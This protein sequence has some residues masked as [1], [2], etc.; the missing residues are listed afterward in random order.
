MWKIEYVLR[1]RDTGE[2]YMDWSS[3]QE[4]AD[5]FA[6]SYASNDRLKETAVL[7]WASSPSHSSISP[8]NHK[9]WPDTA[10]SQ[11]NQVISAYGFLFL[12]QKR[13]LFSKNKKAHTTLLGNC[14]A[15]MLCIKIQQGP[16]TGLQWSYFAGKFTSYFHHGNADMHLLLQNGNSL[17]S[18]EKLFK[19]PLPSCPSEISHF[20]VASGLGNEREGRNW[21]GQPSPSIIKPTGAVAQH[22]KCATWEKNVKIMSSLKEGA[23][24]Q[25]PRL[26][27]LDSGKLCSWILALQRGPKYSCSL[28]SRR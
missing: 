20:R 22:W 6:N 5:D 16:G 21:T 23:L 11:R 8:R 24:S 10:A 1:V 19:H 9:R 25:P 13:L 7:S 17:M 12:L 28:T 4:Q 2:T 3:S 27:H 15:V 26:K 14:H 18:V